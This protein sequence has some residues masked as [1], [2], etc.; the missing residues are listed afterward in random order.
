[1]R[2]RLP[3]T[4]AKSLGE[5]LA[6]GGLTPRNTN[7]KKL[8]TPGKLGLGGKLRPS[9]APQKERQ[10][11]IDFNLNDD[12]DE[13]LSLGE[14][15]NM[16]EKKKMAPKKLDFEETVDA[17]AQEDDSWKDY[18]DEVEECSYLWSIPSK[19]SRRPGMLVH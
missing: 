7:V 17:K 14:S 5:A 9:T 6:R 1:M 15:S 16:Q 4:P 10:Q 2:N 13:K 19:S 12:F 3:K 11:S 18:P 8:G